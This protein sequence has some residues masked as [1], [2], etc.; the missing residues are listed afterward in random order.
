MRERWGDMTDAHKLIGILRRLYDS[1]VILRARLPVLLDLV[2]KEL[3]SQCLSHIAEMVVSFI[4]NPSIS[5][6]YN[7]VGRVGRQSCK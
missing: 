7:K 6:I 3:E 4:V 5:A 2:G 1:L